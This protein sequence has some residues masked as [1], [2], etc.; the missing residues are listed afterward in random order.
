MKQKL[1]L[2]FLV[3][4]SLQNYAQDK[5]KPWSAGIGINTVDISP[6]TISLF[7]DQFANDYLNPFTDTNTFPFFS[8]VF[9][10]RYLNKNFTLDLALAYNKLK[11][12]YGDSEVLDDLNYLSGDLGVRYDINNI[13]GKT[14]WFDPYAKL[15]AGLLLVDGNDMSIPLLGGLG[16]N[17][18]FNDVLGL[19]IETNY[20]SSSL[21][22]TSSIATVKGVGD[23]HFQHAISLVY[24]FGAKDKDKDGVP[25]KEDVCPEESGSEKMNGCPDLDGDEVIDKEDKCPETPGTQELFGCPEEKDQ[26]ND[27]VPD[28][29]DKCLELAGSSKTLGCPDSDN[30][31]IA[32]DI[33]KCPTI[34]GPKENEGCP[35]PEALSLS[36]SDAA[37]YLKLKGKQLQTIQFKFGAIAIEHSVQEKLNDIVKMLLEDESKVAGLYV[38]GHT[39]SV[40]AA[41]FNMKLSKQR[42][43]SIAQYIV[44]QGIDRSRLYVLCFGETMP[45]ATNTTTEGRAKNRRVE[46]SILVLKRN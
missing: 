32:D 37:N 2:L 39:D 8:R 14:G 23:Y 44:D 5:L 16:F 38:E 42:A 36:D 41:S 35:E 17:I 13:I 7:G 6:Y 4:I 9:I 22:G 46:V 26:D 3:I 1:T 18:W 25:D 19:N 29:I 40:G 20:K 21:F 12:Q 33:D 31:G 24:K 43:E 27:G 34:A 11:K 45:I 30:D 28:K 15:G 10:T